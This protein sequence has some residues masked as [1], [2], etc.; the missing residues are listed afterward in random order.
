MIFNNYPAHPTH[1]R[2]IKEFWVFQDTNKTP[3]RH[4]IIPD[5]Y[6][7]IIFHFGDPYRIKLNGDWEMQPNALFA[8]QITKHF[9]LEN[10]G[11]SDTLGVKLYPDI[12]A[13]LFRIDMST[14]TDKVVDLGMVDTMQPLNELAKT[15]SDK[16]RIEIVS[17]WIDKLIF[18]KAEWSI[19]SA[20]DI[21]L[22][23]NGVVGIDSLSKKCGMSKRHLERLFKLKIGLSPKLLARI[24]RFSYI[25]KNVEKS[26]PSWI[27]LA[28][29]SGYF[30]QSHFI[31]DFKEFTGE[32][33]GKY[34]F[35][36]KNMA[37]FF[38]LK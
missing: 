11:C 38:L 28:F 19:H 8:G 20:V 24:I 21:I 17:K 33:P 25:F 13:E 26:G 16:D 5:G 35:N 7:E 1:V 14:V 22:E 2:V 27:D 9:F 37:N 6:C 34:G 30:D 31:R 10:T 29:K 32:E 15:R 4:K 18:E 23:R 36:E 12:A 3:G